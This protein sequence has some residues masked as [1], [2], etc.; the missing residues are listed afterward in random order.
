MDQ[1]TWPVP[2]GVTA[3][4]GLTPAPIVAGAADADAEA[5][6]GVISAATAAIIRIVLTSR[7][8]GASAGERNAVS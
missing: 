3:I 8:I 7:T 5:T 2:F 1:T 4:R 6:A